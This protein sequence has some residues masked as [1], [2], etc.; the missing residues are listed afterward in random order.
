[1]Y[2]N[3]VE[4]MGFYLNGD[5]FSEEMAHHNFFHWIRGWYSVLKSYIEVYQEETDGED[6]TTT[7]AGLKACISA[8]PKLR[9]REHKSPSFGSRNWRTSGI[10]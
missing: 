8:V 5:V 1:V 7:P 3:D 2:K 6:E 9:R 4:D 10:S